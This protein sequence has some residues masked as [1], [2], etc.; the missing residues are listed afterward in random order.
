MVMGNLCHVRVVDKNGENVD[1]GEEG[2]VRITSPFEGTSLIDYAPGD[3]TKL[4]SSNSTVEFK[5]WKINIPYPLLS[6]DIRRREENPCVRIREHP[7]SLN[8]VSEIL[9]SHLGY[10]F[11]ILKPTTSD[12]LLL[13]VPSNIRENAY[14][15]ICQKIRYIVPHPLLYNLVNVKKV[16]EE[17][18]R[19][20]VYP[21]FHHKPHN[22]ILS[23]SKELEDEI[24]AL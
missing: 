8:I 2:E 18:L 1:E 22:I 13:L 15:E 7:L 11:A 21:G 16:N 23:P 12:E 17:K 9:S 14:N 5:G 3:V 4:L 19:K 6:W 10:N 20:I 24:S